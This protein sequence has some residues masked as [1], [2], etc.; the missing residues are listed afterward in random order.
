MVAADWIADVCSSDL[1]ENVGQYNITQGTLALSG[2]Y[3]LSYVGA[4]LTI[5]PRAVEVTADAQAKVYGDADPAL[6]YKI[7]SGSLV[8]SDA[9][10]GAP[11]RVAG[12]N[13][14]Q[15]N[16]TQGTLALSGNYTLSYVG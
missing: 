13:V 2:N 6:T 9:F 8:G 4:K 11:S 16:I 15:Y 7:T 5:G 3:T 12:E 14:G 10:A 1:G